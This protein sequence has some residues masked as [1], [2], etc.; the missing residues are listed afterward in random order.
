MG[1]TS[2]THTDTDVE[3][4]TRYVYRVKAINTKGAGHYSNPASLTTPR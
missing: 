4:G 2:T 1:S 3:P